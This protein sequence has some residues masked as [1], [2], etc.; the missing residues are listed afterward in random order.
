VGNWGLRRLQRSQLEGHLWDATLSQSGPYVCE[1]RLVEHRPPGSA[2][3]IQIG[4]GLTDAAPGSARATYLAVTNIEAARRE[5]TKRGVRISDIRHKSPMDDW[6]GGWQPGADP[7]HRDYASLADFTDPRR[8]HLD[9]PGNRLPP[10][11][12]RQRRRAPGLTHDLDRTTRFQTMSI[13]ARSNCGLG[14]P[15]VPFDRNDL[16]ARRPDRMGSGR[17]RRDLMT[18]VW[19]LGSGYSTCNSA[20]ETTRTPPPHDPARR[21]AQHRP[22]V[23]QAP[24]APRP[25]WRGDHQ[26]RLTT[27]QPQ[28]PCEL[29]HSRKCESGPAVRG[30][31]GA[32]LYTLVVERLRTSSCMKIR[33]LLTS[34]AGT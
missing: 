4:V 2:C 15:L 27:Q 28:R 19:L 7:K 13:R 23:V 30:S 26:S 32:T 3:S 18:P 6:R 10:T 33:R 17:T 31:P 8:Q 22:P 21:Q 14:D 1:I 16:H 9:P 11:G 34:N 12:H 29:L 5:L 20:P 25:T 24:R